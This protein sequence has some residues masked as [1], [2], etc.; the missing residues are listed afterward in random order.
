MFP[1]LQTSQELGKIKLEND[2][3]KEN[4]DLPYLEAIIWDFFRPKDFFP[5]KVCCIPKS[6]PIK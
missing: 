4:I 3:K 5:P 6:I 1:S 2:K